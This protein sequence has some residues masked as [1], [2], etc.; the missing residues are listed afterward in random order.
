MN[1][2][3][4]LILKGHSGGG[5]FSIFNKLI[6]YLQN[7]SP[8]YAITYE[9]YHESYGEGEIFG[10][11]LNEY[12]DHTYKDYNI[13]N[14]IIDNYLDNTITGR[15]AKDIYL[16]NNMSW[17]D[18]IYELFTKYIHINP[19]ILNKLEEMKSNI[20]KDHRIITFLVRHPVLKWE[21][22]NQNMPF[23]SQYTNAIIESVDDIQK[24]TIIC[25][26]DH[27]EAYTYFNEQFQGVNII[28]PE[29]ERA[30]SDE[31]EITRT[32]PIKN[33]DR[34]V[35]ALLSVLYLSIGDIFIH[36]VSNMATAGLFMNPK[37]KS[38][39]LIG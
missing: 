25:M 17:R 34:A 14:I 3:Y 12:R 1:K 28:F 2:A 9:V 6:N 4:H 39:F 19:I 31:T 33:I 16:T 10:K 18:N 7:Y 38:K 36:P 11:I 32:Q 20:P 24:T 35:N 22:P 13:E 21:Q 27:Q 23:F 37:M 8:I 15:G 26:T 5:F 30:R 29:V